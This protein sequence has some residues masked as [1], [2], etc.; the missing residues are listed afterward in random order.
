MNPWFR[1]TKGEGEDRGYNRIENNTVAEVMGESRK[2]VPLGYV[3][4]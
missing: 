4:A 1:S 3:Y 2:A